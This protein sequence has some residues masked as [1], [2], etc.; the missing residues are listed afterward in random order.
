MTVPIETQLIFGIPLGFT[1]IPLKICDELKSLQGSEQIAPDCNFD[2][3]VDKPNLKKDLANI[4]SLWITNIIGNKQKW[5]MTTNWITENTKG[6]P[7]KQ[8]SHKNCSYSAVLYFDKISKD[9]PPLMI[10]NPLKYIWGSLFVETNVAP[11]VFTSCEYPAPCGEGI[12]IFFPSYLEHYHSP[13]KSKQ[14]RRSFA[15]NF[16]PIGKYGLYDSTLDTNLLQ[17]D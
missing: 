7:M 16:F 6:L 13:F 9:H 17:Y 12:M 5:V 8:H 15:C 2:V 14:N 1:K 11:N 4:F 3:L 10:C